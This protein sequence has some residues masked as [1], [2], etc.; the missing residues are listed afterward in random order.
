MASSNFAAAIAALNALTSDELNAL[1][2][3]WK[4]ISKTKRS[5]TGAKAVES[6]SVQIGQLV[7]W[8]STKRSDPGRHYLTVTN[9]NRAMT[10]AVGFE[11]DATGKQLLPQR[12]WTVALTFIKA[13]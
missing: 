13:V 12:K 1:V 3:Y 10:C 11:C 7:C 5:I 8:D 2:P 4:Q 6:G 9:F